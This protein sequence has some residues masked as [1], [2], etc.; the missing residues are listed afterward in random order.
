MMDDDA[1]NMTQPTRTRKMSNQGRALIGTML[2]KMSLDSM[3]SPRHTDSSLHSACS[4]TTPQSLWRAMTPPHA[5]ARSNSSSSLHSP[6]VAAACRASD[7]RKTHKCVDNFGTTINLDHDFDILDSPPNTR[8]LPYLNGKPTGSGRKLTPRSYTD[9]SL[10]L[11]STVT[12][13]YFDSSSDEEEAKPATTDPRKPRCCLT[14]EEETIVR[15][16]VTVEEGDERAI[17]YARRLW[18]LTGYACGPVPEALEEEIKKRGFDRAAVKKQLGTSILANLTIPEEFDHDS[19]DDEFLYLEKDNFMTSAPSL[20]RTR[21]AG[22]CTSRHA[23]SDSDRRYSAPD[24]DQHTLPL[25]LY[26]SYKAGNV[27]SRHKKIGSKFD[28]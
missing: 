12:K 26:K 19:S 24:S 18:A 20:T 3:V 17:P 2:S 14:G 6:A 7:T 10:T 1:E 13:D 28:D 15:K 8:T 25:F 11:P 27:T 21:G 5:I 22:L 9:L 4:S 16:I 23:Y